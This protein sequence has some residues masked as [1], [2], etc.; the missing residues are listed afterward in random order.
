MKIP[1]PAARVT[2]IMFLENC[3]VRGEDWGLLNW[4]VGTLDVAEREIN[5]DIAHVLQDTSCDYDVNDLI[6]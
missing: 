3:M 2:E 6:T 1:I 5:G 4:V